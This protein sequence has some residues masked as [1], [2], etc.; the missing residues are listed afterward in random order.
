MVVQAESMYYDRTF[1]AHLYAQTKE[2]FLHA[3]YY[4]TLVPSYPSG[5]IGF[6]Y[7][8]KTMDISR[9]NNLCFEGDEAYLAD[10]VYYTPEIHTAS[11]ALPAFLKK[12][13]I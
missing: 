5:S 4:F 9:P 11:F 7:G 6:V 12:L 13:L 2:L 10:L 3:G 8:S 1:I